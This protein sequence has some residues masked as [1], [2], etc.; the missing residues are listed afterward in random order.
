MNNKKDVSYVNNNFFDSQRV[1]E[2][3][4]K[5]EQNGNISRNASILSNHFGSGVLLNSLGQKILFDSSDLTESQASLLAAN[6]FDGYGISTH[7]QPSDSIFG[8][9]IEV[10]LSGSSVWGRFSTKV[11]IVGLDF[12]G[13]LQWD[14]FYFHKDGSFVTSKHY[15]KILSL[16]FNDFKGNSN[17]SR[18][19]GGK[20]IL[21]ET[22][23][24]Q[25]STDC[26]SVSQDLEPDL[27]WRDFKLNN[28]FLTLQQVLQEGIGNT[29]NA[30]ALEINTT[31]LDPKIID[32]NDIV[33]HVGQKFL[34][35]TNNIQKISLL[36][37]ISK[38]S[39][40]SE[41]DWYDWSGDLI[42]SLY[43]LQTTTS[44]PTDVIP[45]LSIDFDPT[46]Q[47]L[48]QISYNQQSLKDLG[49]VLTDILQPVDFVFN[50]TK[51]SI[52]GGI[53][54]NKYYIV[55]VKR[56]GDASVGTIL[57]GCGNNKTEGRVSLFNGSWVD[58]EEQDLWFQIWS[59]AIKLSD[60]KAYDAGNGIQFDKTKLSEETGL[61]IDN[62]IKNLS[63]A[64]TGESFLNIG[65]ISA[66]EK[67]FKKTQNEKSG[68]KV[69]SLKQYIPSFSFVSELDLNSIRNTLDPVII[70]T[71]KDINPKNNNTILEKIQ[72]I[73]GLAVGDTFCIVNPD[74]DLLSLNL[75][76]SKLIPN[77]T[78]SNKEYRIF[79]STYCIDGYGDL[80]AD[81]K[82]D[83]QD[84]VRISEL[85][86]ESLYFEST[87]QKIVDGYFD[88][89]ELLKADLNGDGYVSSEDVDLL[90]SY[91]NKT[92][93]S[94]PV[95]SSFSHLCLKVQSAVGRY[96]GYYDCNGMIRLDGYSGQNIID[97]NTLT[98]AELE[99]DGYY[100]DIQLQSDLTFGI[101]PFVPITYQII[102][103]L[104]WQDWMVLTTSDARIVP[105]IFSDTVGVTENK[106]ENN[107]I[108]C[109]ERNFAN[110]PVDVGKNDVFFPDDIYL[111]RG[112][113][114]RLD[115]SLVK[116][117]I[118]IGTIILQLPQVPLA[119]ASLNIF[120]KFIVD[121]GDGFTIAGFKAMKYADCSTVQ[122]ED[123]LLNKLKFNVA[124]QSF[125]PNLDG[126]S[127][128]D[129]YGV[130]V[131]DIIG[132]YMDSET[133]ILTLSVKDLSVDP[134]YLTL[135]SKIQITVYL[136]K[137]GWNNEILTIGPNQ[138]QG[139]LS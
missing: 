64:Y 125:Y 113:I 66:V 112:Q 20:I 99:Y 50:N 42:I 17:C 93:N 9:Q 27:F 116:P 84:L 78:F 138:L 13:N 76:G 49:Y 121:Q 69:Q 133:G 114:R 122:R 123:L 16:F 74:P 124:I 94:F 63:F 36:L 75:I 31:G 14:K 44:C 25:L 105:T 2:L 37:G 134:I 91:V 95:G 107:S 15:T 82:I 26:L 139:L 89:I 128:I 45:E 33:S 136:K 131:D 5:L 96:D 41:S 70:G 58:I 47:P 8:N 83:E 79:K 103:Q 80:N 34:A 110:E 130:I 30:D 87:Q 104:F 92:T 132:I 52:P 67:Y 97:P 126:Y 32:Q 137:S 10:I 48:V 19:F 29:F 40:V 111:K 56:S 59:N 54:E 90:T 100:I 85:V 62:E 60:G 12:E 81:G 53:L 129:G 86:G 38:N 24:F 7:S 39:N 101:V 11:A 109:S 68:E 108:L 72:T 21:K 127:E 88:V 6:L 106:C 98:E 120:D 4:L 18:N 73:P 3:E 65:I 135:V 55:T 43:P 61:P 71:A 1:G 28:S 23:S 35:K 77:T 51:I 115:G 46:N 119:E 117:D 102:P 118:E 57:V 22:E